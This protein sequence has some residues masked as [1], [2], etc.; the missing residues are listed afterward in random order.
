MAR[1][2]TEGAL[3]T[4]TATAS[5]SDPSSDQKASR[6][7]KRDLSDMAQGMR[8]PLHNSNLRPLPARPHVLLFQAPWSSFLCVPSHYGSGQGGKGH[9]FFMCSLGFTQNYVYRTPQW[10]VVLCACTGAKGPRRSQSYRSRAGALA[11]TGL[12]L[13]RVAQGPR[14]EPELEGLLRPHRLSPTPCSSLQS[15]CFAGRLSHTTGNERFSA[16]VMPA[17]RP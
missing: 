16:P 1:C 10:P 4:M 2:C 17:A 8:Q 12:S 11:L 3:A 7:L 6:V 13:V 9:G 5:L 15:Q 14:L